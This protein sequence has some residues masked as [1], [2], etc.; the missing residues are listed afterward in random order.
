LQELKLTSN[1]DTFSKSS[2]DIQSLSSCKLKS[3]DIDDYIFQEWHANK[4]FLSASEEI[5]SFKLR[6]EEILPDANTLYAFL[7]RI[8]R[9]LTSLELLA[10]NNECGIPIY[11]GKLPLLKEGNVV[12]PELSHLT[13]EKDMFYHSEEDKVDF[14]GVADTLAYTQYWQ[15]VEHMLICPKLLTL[16]LGYWHSDPPMV[17]MENI[18]NL[19]LVEFAKDSIREML[20]MVPRLENL[21]VILRN[22]EQIYRILDLTLP[23]TVYP[24]RVEVE[25]RNTYDYTDLHG[26]EDTLN[27]IMSRKRYMLEDGK[28][29]KRYCSFEWKTKSGRLFKK[30]VSHDQLIILVHELKRK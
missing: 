11:R 14:D 21:T 2:I 6:T 13:I 22:S 8:S 18:T 9:S 23:D 24:F 19:I 25:V 5:Q 27:T 4:A 20:Y 1:F 15:T 10:T 12:L 17:Q 29:R 28:E 7:S 3:L 16:T 26:L 30:V